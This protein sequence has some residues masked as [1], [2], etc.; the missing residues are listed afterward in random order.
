MAITSLSFERY[1][2]FKDRQDV[3]LAQVTIII[4][5]NGSGKS[6]LS[7]L[8]LLIEKALSPSPEGI[9][10][11]SAGDID[12]AATFQDL[13][14]ARGALPFLLGAAMD[15]GED[16]L[17]FETRI[18]YV[19][20]I[21]LL[22]VESCVLRRNDD[23]VFEA[24]LADTGDPTYSSPRYRVSGVE[25][26]P[27]DL[28]F[29]GLLPTLNLPGEG[30]A[31]VD[32]LRAA[33]PAT[34]YLGPF[35]VESGASLKMPSQHID[36]LGPRGQ[37]AL[38]VL[39]DD[40]LRHGGA[41]SRA[42]ATWFA[43]AMGSALEIDVTG[44]RP[45]VWVSDSGSKTEVDLSDTGAGFSQ[46]VPVVIQHLAY[47]CGRLPAGL[48]I[49]EQPELHLHPAAHGALADLFIASAR[50]GAQVLVETHSEQLIMRFRRRI[51]DGTLDASLVNLVSV[52]HAEG[53]E[54]APLPV[55]DVSFNERG[56]PSSW[57]AGVFEESLDDLKELRAAARARAK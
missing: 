23:R 11:L 30:E 56:D 41:L 29:K 19:H 27:V 3:R 38:E 36:S 25:G 50:K 34:S 24:T 18:R 57:P 7:R 10:S 44:D 33:M 51:A 43:Q 32:L 52:D 53:L 48:L 42:V 55:C 46:S 45:R 13:V 17:R 12:H 8:P 15:V 1:R 39:A 9:L 5:K 31:V 49:V 54:E 4:G 20:E 37:R 40:K 47:Q 28:G 6:V 16:V 14:H 21:R 2:K 26:E 22:V 35:R